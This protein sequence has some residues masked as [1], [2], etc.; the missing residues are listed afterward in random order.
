MKW[1]LKN[2]INLGHVQTKCPVADGP[3]VLESS[4]EM[5]RLLNNEVNF[6]AIDEDNGALL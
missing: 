1:V 3:W 4:D 2:E 5:E 6:K